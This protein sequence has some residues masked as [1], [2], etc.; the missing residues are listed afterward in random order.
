MPIAAYNRLIDEILFIT[1]YLVFYKIKSLGNLF[2]HPAAKSFYASAPLM[3]YG[4]K[5]KN[6]VQGI[7][8]LNRDS[9][10]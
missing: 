9:A 3:H 1:L 8:Y 5:I 4:P 7:L 2:N 6:T 10:C